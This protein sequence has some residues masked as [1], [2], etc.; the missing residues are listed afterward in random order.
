MLVLTVFT[1]Q[2]P[3]TT[4]ISPNG[5]VPAMKDPNNDDILIW[6]SGAMI[7]YLI[8]RYDS[9]AHHL[10]YDEEKKNYQ[11]LTWLHF[12]MSGQG[13]Y[14]GQCAWFNNMHPEK[15]ESAIERYN[16][17]L[18]RITSVIDTALQRNGTGY[19]VGNKPTYADLA[20]IPWYH[21]LPFILKGDEKKIQGLK[22]KYPRY[23]EW[24][25]GLTRRE[26]V[27]KVLEDRDR[28]LRG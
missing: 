23:A 22:E 4:E 7:Q 21:L 16:N 20:F 11:C 2:P 15:V 1:P 27:K 8:D 6:E 17:E 25:A 24:M 13:P 18:D 10:S 14:F 19:L 5:R 28:A 12:Q 26:K 9:K 3:F